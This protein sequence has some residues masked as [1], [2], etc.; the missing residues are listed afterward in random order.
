MEM[1]LSA[2]SLAISFFTLGGG[3][4]VA[5]WR[6]GRLELKADTAWNFIVRRA[7]ME[8]K[9]RGVVR[10]NSPLTLS[11]EAREAYAPI[12]GQ[13]RDFYAK[14]GHRLNDIE[15]YAEIERRFADR[16]VT[17]ICPK[18]GLLAGGCLVL[19]AAVAK[20]PLAGVPDGATT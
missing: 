2:V 10:E 19:A 3:I 20:E 17:E 5:G 1:I 6:L 11:A 16:L 14:A 12:A 9:Y 8:A 7:L 4:Y 15:L 18:L 13:L